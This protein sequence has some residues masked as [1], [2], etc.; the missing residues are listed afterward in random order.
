[1]RKQTQGHKISAN[2]YNPIMQKQETYHQQH[3]SQY[4]QPVT[5]HVLILQ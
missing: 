3:Q 1:M 4:Q 5:Q 2:N